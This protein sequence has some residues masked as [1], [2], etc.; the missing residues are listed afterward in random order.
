MKDIEY[1]LRPVTRY[2]I[3]RYENQ[4]ENGTAAI[5]TIGEFDNQR[6]AFD[7]GTALC[8]N[9]FLGADLMP[10]DKFIYPQMIPTADNIPPVA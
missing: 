8:R 9:E 4:G 7:V 6:D 2:V 10:G 1:R 3:T 5:R